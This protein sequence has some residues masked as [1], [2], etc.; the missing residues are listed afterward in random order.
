MT[1]VGG[2]VEHELACGNRRRSAAARRTVLVIVHTLVYGQRLRDLFLPL[3]SDPRIRVTFTVAPHRFDAGAR[4]FLSDAGWAAMPWER[5]I[6]TRF[7]LALAAGSRGIERVSAPIILIPHGASHIKL[8]R[9]PAPPGAVGQRPVH[10]LS[11]EYLMRDNRVVPKIIALAHEEERAE[12]A[13]WCPEA[14]PMTEVVGDPFLDRIMFSLPRRAEYRRALGLGEDGKLIVA[15]FT[16]QPKISSNDLKALLGRIQRELA[17]PEYRTVLLIHPNAREGAGGK[18]LDS[19]LEEYRS[20]G[21][22]MIAPEVDWRPLLIAADWIIGD[23]GS[24]TLY[25]TISR[26]P[27]LLERFPLASVSPISPAAELALVAPR[28]LPLRPLAEQLEAATSGYRLDRH[29]AIA[30]RI[31]SEPGQFDRNIRRLLY[32]LLALDP[33]VHWPAGDPLPLPPSLSRPQIRSFSRFA[34]LGLFS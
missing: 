14:L 7:D 24:I 11:R 16:W 23:H 26:T 25:G 33:P 15:C 34:S 32:R 6:R 28:V 10:G 5:A 9:T 8:A 27:I 30:A 1:V 12:L 17:A 18:L 29:A 4:R 19:L 13:R 20:H 31:A 21:I 3:A 2:L 22:E